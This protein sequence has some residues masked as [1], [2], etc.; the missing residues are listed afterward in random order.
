MQ[1]HFKQYSEVIKHINKEWPNGCVCKVCKA[2][3]R[4]EDIVKSK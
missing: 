1:I 2:V 3:D 4:Q